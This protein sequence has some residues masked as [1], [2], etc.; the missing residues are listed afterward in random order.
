MEKRKGWA[1]SEV[2]R[3][4]KKQR[5]EDK[6]LDIQSLQETPG[7]TGL[8][9]LFLSQLHQFLLGIPDVG[10]GSLIIRAFILTEDRT[11]ASD[12]GSLAYHSFAS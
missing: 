12:C 9:P 11:Q 3:R 10:S 6:L 2:K 1:E 4:E 5:K 7:V 8:F